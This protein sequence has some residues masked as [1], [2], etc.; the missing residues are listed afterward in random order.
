[1]DATHDN[2]FRTRRFSV[3]DLDQVIMINK[4]CLPE[5]YPS[6]FFVDIYE[7]YPK[8]FLVSEYMSRKEIVGYIMGRIE[9]GLSN[10]G[11]RLTRKGHIVSVAVLHEYRKNGI[12][13][14]LASR[15]LEAMHDYGASEYVLEVRM[16]NTPAVSLYKKMGFTDAKVLR[17]YYSDGEDAYLMSKR[18][19]EQSK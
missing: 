19:E 11:F 15:S 5:N 4:K 18:D 3:K 16:S 1:M 2:S 13:Y 7:R 6:G 8:S 17:G 9:R 12:A 14:D 10:F